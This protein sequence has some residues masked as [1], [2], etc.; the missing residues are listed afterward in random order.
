MTDAAREH[1]SFDVIVCGSGLAGL[2]AAVTAAEAGARVLLLEKG[3]RPGGTTHLSS[4]TVW[5]WRDLVKLQAAIPDGD[6]ILQKVVFDR[7]D[8]GRDWL[9]EH[10]V[11]LD[12]EVTVQTHGRGRHMAPSQAIPALIARLEDAGGVLRLNTALDE[13]R[14]DAGTVVGLQADSDGQPLEL[15]ARAIIL[16]TGG[17]QGNPELISRYLG[18]PPENLHLRANPWSTGDGFLAALKIGA[19]ASPGLETFYGH[20][21][22]APP[23][24]FDEEHF[25]EVSQYYGR[26]SVA[27]NLSGVRFADESEG[28]GEEVLNQRLARQ[29]G[30]LGFYI[31]D[32]EI[33]KK[34]YTGD[35]VI[36]VIVERAR[37]FGATMVVA[38]TLEELAAG[39]GRH[40][41]PPSVVIATLKRFNEAIASGT[42]GDLVPPR[43]GNHFALTT[44]PFF[45]VGV[46][47]SITLTMGGLAADSQMRVIRRASSNSPL[48]QSIMHL[49]E[50]RASP[51]PGL[52][53][54]GG[55]LGNLSH[56]GYMGMLGAGLVS[57]RIAGAE[58]A[59]VAIAARTTP[60]ARSEGASALAQS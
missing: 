10:G 53:A 20:A 19:A 21:L 47:A 42:T 18:A 1:D 52:Y 41:L 32:S 26:F 2:C 15:R 3:P 5:T 12:R 37:R 22:L 33:A 35:R 38:D 14:V 40:G 27:I 50:Y 48:A 23:A 36:R 44:P 16:A 7:I 31:I 43:R 57:G 11:R 45:A 49:D 13:L 56:L 24:T 34:C 60:L 46:K 58:A 55:D 8:E 9:V 29:P 39:L 59:S 30:G 28:T 17:F 54:A 6:P 51:I 25:G 4:G